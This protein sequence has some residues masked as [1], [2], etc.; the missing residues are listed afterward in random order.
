VA[1]PQAYPGCSP[2][3]ETVVT[4]STAGGSVKKFALAGV[5]ALTIG[6]VAPAPVAQAGKDRC[7]AKSE[8][9]KV[10]NGMSKVQVTR[11]IGY[12]GT[13]FFD[14]DQYE[15]REYASCK[16]ESGFVMVSFEHNK[17]TKK[18]AVWG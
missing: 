1:R 15:T 14:F 2:V 3:V 6:V 5:L 11:T 13:R 12:R 7:A 10:K 4:V 8:Y 9:R 16:S 17:V 18:S